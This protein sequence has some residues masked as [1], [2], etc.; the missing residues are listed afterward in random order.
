MSEQNRSYEEMLRAERQRLSRVHMRNQVALL[1][2]LRERLGDEVLSVAEQHTG[3]AARQGWS[4]LAARHGS[5]SIADLV[6]LLWEPLTAQ[7][8]EYTSEESDGGLKMTCTKCPLH[9][10]AKE[11]GHAEIVY[12][13]TCGTDP[14]MVEGF[15][16][17]M[18]FRRTKTLMQGHDCCDHFYYMKEE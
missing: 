5:N 8:L 7:G 14:Y 11:I 9:E 6:K 18:G 3:A 2:A 12:A 15:N 13:L 4:R 1:A 16:A 17:K 10:L